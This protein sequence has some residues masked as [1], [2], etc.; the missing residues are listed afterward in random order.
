MLKDE[1]KILKIIFT[2]YN[3]R[4]FAHFYELVKFIIGPKVL[5]IGPFRCTMYVDCCTVV[6][7]KV[8]R[9]F[10]TVRVVRLSDVSCPA[11]IHPIPNER[12]VYPSTEVTGYVPIKSH[13]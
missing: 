1:Q 6:Q 4:K 5:V 2:R 8:L 11:H 7:V 12:Y 10:H 3:A 9:D 13:R